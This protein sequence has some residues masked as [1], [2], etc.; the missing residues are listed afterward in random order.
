[1]GTGF[2]RGHHTHLVQ[3]RNSL[4]NPGSSSVESP[5]DLMRMLGNADRY[6]NNR[7]KGRT[8]L[9]AL[10]EEFPV[11]YYLTASLLPFLDDAHIGVDD[12]K[13]ALAE[14]HLERDPEWQAL[15]MVR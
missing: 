4:R 3:V 10:L 9:E 12:E 13:R 1:M 15:F 6:L 5:L 2:D 14:K 8:S 11:I 7:F